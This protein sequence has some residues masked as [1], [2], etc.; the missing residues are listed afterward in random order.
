MVNFEFFKLSELAEVIVSGVDKKSKPGQKEVR[1]C[2]FTDVYYN[3]AITSSMYN[4]FMVATA[5]NK[6]IETL[7]I[8]KGYVALTKDSETRYDMGLCGGASLPS[9]LQVP[10]PHYRRRLRC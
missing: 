6:E 9:W 2:N 4:S 10:V 3:W 5:K 8:K 1:L 7:S